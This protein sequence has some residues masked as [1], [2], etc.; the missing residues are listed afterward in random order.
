MDR[1][2]LADLRRR[3]DRHH[4]LPVRRGA[5]LP[6][7]RQVR[8]GA[9][10]RRG[11]PRHLR[12]RQL[13]PRADG[14]RPGD[15]VPGPGRPAP[16]GQ[17]PR[18]CRSSP[19]TTCTTPARRTPP[20]HEVL[21]C[22]QSGSTMADPNRF[23]LDGDDYYLKSP[24]EM[25]EVW[26]DLPEAC[27]NTLLIAERCEVSFTEGEG[28][29]MPRFPVPD[30][31]VGAVLVRQGGRARACARATPAA[32]RDDVRSQA[33]Y[34]TEVICSQGLR[35]LLPGRRRLHQLGQ[36]AR[37][38]GRPGPWLRRRLD[39]RVR[40]ADHRPRP[41][42]AR[43]D[44]RA[45]PQP[46]AHVDARLRRRL[47]RA[48]PRR[49]DPLRHREVRR[50]PGGPDRHLRHHQGQAGDEGLG[51][52]ARLPLRAGRPAHQADAAGRH[53]QGHPARRHLRPAATS[54]TPRP[55][56]SGPA[57]SPTRTP[58]GSSTPRA[59]WRTSSA[60]GACTRPA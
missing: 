28:R 44:L 9:R 54:A 36:G 20:A 55:A 12:R 31:R 42:A 3:A 30:G 22:V 10:G 41:A 33:E 15:R 57:T 43:P 25:R 50:R 29:Y 14:P 26:R 8:R 6:A 13:L 53:G 32:S 21:L 60:S 2:L 27:D 11:V 1:E 16:A 7:A 24:E 35:R 34:E 23:K 39:V 18:A 52:G 46:G 47:R 37:H 59:A 38:P 49:G 58:S 40:D 45:V 56:S 17:G 51:P 5:D 4:R 19:P 48:P